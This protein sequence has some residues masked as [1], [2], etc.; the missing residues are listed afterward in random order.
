MNHEIEHLR[1]GDQIDWEE[2][3]LGELQRQ[4]ENYRNSAFGHLEEWLGAEGL[5]IL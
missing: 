1:Y 2:Y 5:R 3:E 4:E